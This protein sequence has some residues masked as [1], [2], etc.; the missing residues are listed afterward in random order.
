MHDADTTFP[1]LSFSGRTREFNL[2]DEQK[3]ISTVYHYLV[4]GL[5]FRRLDKEILNCNF[6]SRG[7]Q[8]MAICHHLGLYNAHKGFFSKWNISDILHYLYKLSKNPDICVIYY[9]IV[10]YLETFSSITDQDKKEVSILEKTSP[11]EELF[12]KNWIKNT[13]LYNSDDS[14]KIDSAILN[15]PEKAESEIRV[16]IRNIE[17]FIRSSTIRESVKSLYNYRSQICGDVILRYGWHQNMDRKE[18]WK[19][20]SSDVHHILPL[21]DGGPDDRRNMLC[22]CPTCHRKFHSG[23]YRIKR[24]N[25]YLSVNDELLGK[26]MPLTAKHEILL[27]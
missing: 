22:L 27:Y 26:R 21:S 3:R 25:S 4:T 9:Y 13:L 23:E 1:E 18:E 7:W 19:Y 11:M 2:Y 6:D 8:S 17:C 15:L 12:E 20:L 24:I 10:K 16:I 5:S 14:L